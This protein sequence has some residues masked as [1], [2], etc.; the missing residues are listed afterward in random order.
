M[1][2][3]TL[4]A[5]EPARLQP[6]RKTIGDDRLF[7]GNDSNRRPSGNPAMYKPDRGF[8]TCLIS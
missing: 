6:P 8:R 7:A 2:A 1:E 3:V 4:L 5:P